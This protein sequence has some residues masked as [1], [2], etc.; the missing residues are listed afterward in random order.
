MDVRRTLKA[1][2]KLAID[3][4]LDDAE[5][6][7]AVRGNIT[8]GL[9]AIDK[10]CRSIWSDWDFAIPGYRR[11]PKRS[12]RVGPSPAPPCISRS[13]DKP[14]NSGTGGGPTPARR[15]ASA[16]SSSDDAVPLP[17]ERMTPKRTHSHIESSSSGG[18]PQPTKAFRPR[19]SSSDDEQPPPRRIAIQ[20]DDD[21]PTRQRF[22]RPKQPVA[23]EAKPR[24]RNAKK[25]AGMPIQ[26]FTRSDAARLRQDN[27]ELKAQVA[28][29]KAAIDR[30][31]LE[32]SRLQTELQR[33]EAEKMKQKSIIAFLKEE[34]LYGR[35]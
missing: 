10:Q 16:S 35:R 28:R 30:A 27:I 29:L 31:Q 9:E 17:S 34:K 14:A 15:G 24:Q 21:P 26:P 33:A 5:R 2:E 22:R 23:S 12:P 13:I 11:S 25:P 3:G 20:P 32:N 18:A 8:R 4:I 19:R 7:C 1:E 6:Q